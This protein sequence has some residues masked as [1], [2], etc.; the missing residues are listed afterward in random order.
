MKQKIKGKNYAVFCFAGIRIFF[1]IYD[2]ITW[3]EKNKK[4]LHIT[5]QPQVKVKAKTRADPATLPCVHAQP[6]CCCRPPHRHGPE[7]A[8]VRVTHLPLSGPHDADKHGGCRKRKPYPATTRV[9][10]NPSW[11][12]VYHI[13]PM[14]W[15]NKLRL[16]CLS[17]VMGLTPA[18][19]RQTE[20]ER[21]VL[22]TIT[23]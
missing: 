6:R 7:R 12:R 5:T 23:K 9:S 20:R 4:A 3:G 15:S 17:Q 1:Y 22:L 8:Q 11:I 2:V 16:R 14:H 13:I 18:V 19:C 10:G 21:E